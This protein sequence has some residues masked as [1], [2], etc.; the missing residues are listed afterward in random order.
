MGV[1]I[2]TVVAV[3]ILVVLPLAAVWVAGR[4][5]DPPRERWALTARPEQEALSAPGLAEYRIRRAYG[6]RDEARWTAVRRA[7]DRGEAA[8]PDLRPAARDWAEAVLAGPEL[9]EA[10]GRVRRTFWL[11]LA[12]SL[13]VIVAVSVFYD[14]SLGVVYGLYLVV[15]VAIRNPWRLRARRA[16]AEAALAANG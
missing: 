3:G 10:T 5:R 7:V 14:A 4:W 2:G 13:L 16:R 9:R 8:P 6:L 1:G 11:W 15:L 12:L